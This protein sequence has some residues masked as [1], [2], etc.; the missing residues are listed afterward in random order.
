M[1]LIDDGVKVPKVWEISG[2]NA[3][4]IKV[5]DRLVFAQTNVWKTAFSVDGT[6]VSAN[7]RVINPNKKPSDVGYYYTYGYFSIALTFTKQDTGESH[8][9]F[10]YYNVEEG[11]I[12][13]CVF[14]RNGSDYKL[15]QYW[16]PPDKFSQPWRTYTWEDARSIQEYSITVFSITSF[17]NHEFYICASFPMRADASYEY[18]SSEPT[19]AYVVEPG[20]L[21]YIRLTSNAS[22]IMSFGLNSTPPAT[23]ALK[24]DYGSTVLQLSPFI[25]EKGRYRTVYPGDTQPLE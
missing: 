20:R 21:S 18:A 22:A 12:S 14:E 13:Y 17:D 10:Y 25:S 24:L 16:M 23:P 6:D 1:I 7:P 3:D 5:D 11:K 9:K 4:R 8:V 2:I 19:D 15:S